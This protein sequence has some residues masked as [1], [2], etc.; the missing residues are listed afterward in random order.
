MGLVRML[1][2]LQ[3]KLF[4][5]FLDKTP[6]NDFPEEIPQVDERWLDGGAPAARAL[7]NAASL[8]LGATDKHPNTLVEEGGR[9]KVK[10]AITISRAVFVNV[11]TEELC[12]FVG[13]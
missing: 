12:L 10:A 1:P 8:V 2:A 13:P 11:C 9:E 3:H 4:S 7:C 6:K 5:T